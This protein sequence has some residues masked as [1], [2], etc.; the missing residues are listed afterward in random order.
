MSVY[1]LIGSTDTTKVQ[2]GPPVSIPGITCR[3]TGE[4]LLTGNDINTPISHH[5]TEA[6]PIM[7]DI[8]QNLG[9]WSTLYSLQAAQWVGKYPS[10]EAQVLS[11]FRQL[12]CFLLLAAA[13]P[14][15]G[16]F[17]A[18]QLVWES[19]QFGAPQKT[20]LFTLGSTGPSEPSWFQELPEATLNCLSSVLRSF[21]A[22]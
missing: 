9:T 12:H 6:H 15:S 1:S 3:Y 10:Q 17:Q 2:V 21:S 14:V 16:F 7:A 5:I 20:L 11:P 19:L 4:G 13:L 22:G 18:A 8:P